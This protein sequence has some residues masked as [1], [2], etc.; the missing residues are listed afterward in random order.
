[1]TSF[2]SVPI[3]FKCPSY[4][5]ACIS[6][7]LKVEKRISCLNYFLSY[8]RILTQKNGRM[9][10]PTPVTN[11]IKQNIIWNDDKTIGFSPSPRSF[12]ILIIS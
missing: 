1:M 4:T 6:I 11:R 9:Y 5:L 3:A 7:L 2:C 12:F 10:L 8:I